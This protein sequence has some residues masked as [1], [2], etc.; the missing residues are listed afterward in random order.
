VEL[1]L[2]R[3]AESPYAT[4]EDYP[5]IQW[6]EQRIDV[7]W[8]FSHILRPRYSDVVI[9][10]GGGYGTRQTGF[11]APAFERPMVPVYSF[12]GASEQ[13]W[14]EAVQRTFETAG[15]PGE[16]VQRIGQRD[17]HM[18]QAVVEAAEIL[19]RNNPYVT[20][21]PRAILALIVGVLLIIALWLTLYAY[22]TL[23][24]QMI[25][26]L[27][28]A[29][30]LSSLLGTTLRFGLR[31]LEHGKSFVLGHQVL[32]ELLVGIVVAFG[33]MLVYLS[34]GVIM[35][36]GTL[37]IKDPADFHRAVLTTSL[38]GLAASLLLEKATER[39]R[40]ALGQRLG[41]VDGGT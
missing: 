13:L 41:E 16:T 32:V 11:V 39:L 4:R 37:E 26:S 5:N 36:G 19:V 30:G 9:A 29:L 28:V 8:N 23:F 22:P 3:E 17:D 34:A 35:T 33:L 6:S 14:S 21:A 10:L 12:P 7:P 15:V 38:L 27:F 2:P 31:M 24:G 40:N 20:P 1:L 18:A 25:I